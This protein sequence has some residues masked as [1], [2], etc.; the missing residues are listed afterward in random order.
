MNEIH[1]WRDGPGLPR[2]VEPALLRLLRS[3]P[4]VVVTG[5][6]QTGKTTLV[7]RL[8]GDGAGRYV[9]LDDLEM[10]DRARRDPETLVEGPGHPV[11]L[12]EV[13]RAPDLLV[14]VKRA[15]DRDRRPGR[16]VLTGSADLLL[17][18]KVSETL[19]GRAAHLV[20]HPLT[21]RERAGLG[22]AG[23]WRE[24]LDAPDEAWPDVV[25]RG[26]AA[27][28]ADWRDE[29]RV[30]GYPVPALHLSD[31]DARAD[32]FA[33]YARTYLERD[34]RDLSAVASLVDFRRLMRAACLRLGNLVNQTELARDVGISQPTAHRHL[35]LL[36]LSYQLTRLAA[37]SVNRTKRLV[38]S[39]KL[40]W[41][42]AG[43]ALHLAGEEEPRGAHLENMVLSDLLAWRDAGPDRPEVLFWRATTGAE[44]DFV[45]ERKGELLPIEVKSSARPRIGDT[46][47]LLAFHEDYGRAARP[48][49][50]LHDGDEIEWVTK[51]VLG[52]PWW[53]VL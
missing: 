31:A 1:S 29:A 28:R 21:R 43:L 50:L 15:V 3:S 41:N 51:R 42:D 53:K 38:K 20:L 10:L 6:R 34:L 18:E 44:V 27:L 30:G 32:W 11:V 46:R 45:I 19:A 36:E 49:L 2:L 17:L 13:Q 47:G 23:V 52:A 37:Y 39:P 8:C 14:A 4:V 9:T 40:Y 26:G 12:D 24:L 5:A 48:G 16:F 7:R 22:R 35:A 33:G 25:A